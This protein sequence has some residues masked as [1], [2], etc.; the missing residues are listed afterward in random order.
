MTLQFAYSEAGAWFLLGHTLCVLI[1]RCPS[2]VNACT[3][4]TRMTITDDVAVQFPRRRSRD[5]SLADRESTA[6]RVRSA[7]TA[8]ALRARNLLRRCCHGQH[9]ERERERA[10]DVNRKPRPPP[11]L[12]AG[13]QVLTNFPLCDSAG[14]E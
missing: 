3:L 14:N 4:L 13:G 12:G 2:R 8:R 6:V 10:G 11:P 7:H 1:A 5:V 9:R